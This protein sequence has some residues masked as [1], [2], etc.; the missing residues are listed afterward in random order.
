[1]SYSRGIRLKRVRGGEGLRTTQT[2]VWSLDFAESAHSESEVNRAFLARFW[3][4]TRIST[5]QVEHERAHD[6][7]RSAGVWQNF[8]P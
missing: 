6:Q 4:S 3:F 7:N 8:P 5:R 2:P 1:M